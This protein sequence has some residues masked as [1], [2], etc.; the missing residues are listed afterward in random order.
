MGDGEAQ[1][2]VPV[3]HCVSACV[4]FGLQLACPSN[5]GRRVGNGE[6]Q[7]QPWQLVAVDDDAPRTLTDHLAGIGHGPAET[8]QRIAVH[9]HHGVEVGRGGEQLGHGGIEHAFGIIGSAFMPISDLFPKAGITFWDVANEMNGGFM[10]DGFT[11]ASGKIAMCIAQNGPGITNF[12]TAIAAAYW[13]HSPVVFITPETGSMTMGLGGF[14]ETEQLPI[15]SKIT[16]FQG[17]VNNPQRMAEIAARCFDRAMSEMGPT[18]LNI[19]RDY[20]YGDITCEIPKPFRL[21]RGPGGEQTLGSSWIE[22]SKEGKIATRR[23]DLRADRVDWF[24]G[25]L[26]HELIHVLLADRVGGYPPARWAEEGL[27][28]LADPTEKQVRHE[29]DFRAAAARGRDFRLAEMLGHT[30]YP[31]ATRITAFY[32]QSA[33]LVRF[34]IKFRTPAE[35]PA[36]LK[37]SASYGYDAALRSTYGINGIADLERRWLN[38]VHSD[39]LAI[40]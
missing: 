26:A 37:L 38:S 36:F 7:L 31:D 24:A 29:A 22:T 5:V 20:F 3:V 13:A 6:L 4:A 23:V 30:E 11:R 17:H 21:D 28:I 14:Q 10:A 25:A 2:L 34:L 12:V 1:T 33:S 32:G 40:R 18:Q 27:A 19:P 35:F 39:E 15:F 8:A 9:A 16:R